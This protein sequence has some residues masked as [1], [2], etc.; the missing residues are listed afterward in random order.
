MLGFLDRLNQPFAN[1]G[2]PDLVRSSQGFLDGLSAH[3]GQGNGQ[4]MQL[5]PPGQVPAEARVGQARSPGQGGGGFLDNL[6]N[7]ISD[8]QGMLMNMGAG[9]LEN[10]W[11]GAGRA[12]GGM[13]QDQARRAQEAQEAQAEAQRQAQLQLGQQHG[14]DPLLFDAGMGQEALTQAMRPAPAPDPFTLSEGQIRYDGQGNEIARGPDDPESQIDMRQVESRYQSIDHQSAT[15]LENLDAAISM[16]DGSEQVAGFG[17]IMANIPGT[18]ARN[19]QGRLDAVRALVGFDQLQQMRENSPTGGALGQVTEREL[20]FLQSVEGSLDQAQSEEQLRQILQRLR[21]GQ[22]YF[23][24]QRR[25][26]YV[27]DYGVEPPSSP[28]GPEARRAEPP[29]PNIDPGAA[30][31]W[32]F[33]TPEE[34][35]L[36]L[37]NGGA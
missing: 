13:Q 11:A 34:R 7:S 30:E 33:M 10:G 16:L 22:A 32:E 20:A 37:Q 25:S 36:F 2:R 15:M 24:E 35:G 4:P 6:S 3:M 23:R 1:A 19:F 26:A 27:Q 17:S 31:N 5:A 18:P 28:F 9:L 29:P 14:I 12:A 8:N 21:D